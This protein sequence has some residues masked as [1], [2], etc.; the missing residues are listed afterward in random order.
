VA[1]AFGAELDLITIGSDEDS[2]AAIGEQA[3]QAFQDQISDCVSRIG[4]WR[5]KARGRVSTMERLTEELLAIRDH[6]R[7][8]ATVLGYSLAAIEE[9]IAGALSDGTQPLDALAALAD[10]FINENTCSDPTPPEP[11]PPVVAAPAEPAPATEPTPEVPSAEELETWKKP[12]IQAAAARHGIPLKD[13][14]TKKARTA[15]ELASAL[16]ALRESPRA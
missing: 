2:R 14:V 16:S 6:A 4:D 5:E 9:S 13:P 7:N 12:Q 8:L 15:L 11:E 1:R 10:G 3:R